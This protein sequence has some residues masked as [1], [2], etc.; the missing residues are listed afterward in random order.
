MP[1][2]MTEET[3]KPSPFTRPGFLVAAAVI[4]VILI[5][6]LVLGIV[7]ATK[8]DE[9][10]APTNTESPAPTSQ[11]SSTSAAEAAVSDASVCGKG[12]GSMSGTVDAAPAAEWQFAGTVSFPTSEKHGPSARNDDGVQM[13]FERSP[14]GA[15]FAAAAGMAQMTA[16]ET[17]LAWTKYGL[18]PGAMRDAGIAALTASPP[19]DDGSTRQSFNGFKL[20]SYD[21]A[22]A[23]VDLGVTAVANGKTIY[24]SM[25]VPLTW[26][27]GDWKMNFT[28]N[29]LK[30][31]VQLPNLA[32]YVLWKE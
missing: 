27:E 9:A 8:P 31:S 12:A 21:G 30:E 20:M 29:N 6:G 28:E 4:A 11:P 3:D 5:T 10:A 26:H 23:V 13:C 18:V 7:N 24:V 32:G 2:A 15:V 19:T 1:R 25:I 22:D 17:K 16:A 14:E